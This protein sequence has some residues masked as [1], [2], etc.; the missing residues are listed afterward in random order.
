MSLMHKILVGSACVVLIFTLWVVIF[1]HKG[2]VD[3][4][5]L[6]IEKETLVEE[7]KKLQEENV[8]LYREVERARNDPE[9]IE[10]VAREELGMIG[11]DE[12]IFKFKDKESQAEEEN[13]ET[14]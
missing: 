12:V 6:R 2:F 5:H 11:K 13:K 10:N 14:E 7:N 4:N 3:F 9:Y 8:D 1:G